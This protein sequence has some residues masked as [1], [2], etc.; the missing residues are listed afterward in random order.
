LAQ[1]KRRMKELE[2]K[3]EIERLW[4]ER[5]NAYRIEKEKEQEE[6]QRQMENVRW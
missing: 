6:F 1:Q 3:R 2:H 4:L 5:L